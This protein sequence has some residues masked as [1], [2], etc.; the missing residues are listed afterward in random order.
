MKTARLVVAL[1]LFVAVAAGT[2]VLPGHR[3]DVAVTMWLQRAAPAP[4]L[5]SAILVFCGD[6]EVSIPAVALVGLLLWRGA[7]PRA[8]T[9]LWLAAGMIVTSFIALALKFV[10]PHPGPPPEFQRVIQRVGL[11]LQQPY[12][13]PSGHTMRATF[14]TIAALGRAPLAGAALVVAMMAALVYLGDHWTSDVLGGL[15]L[16]WACAEAARPFRPGA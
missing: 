4:D 11:G 15:C 7:L 13:F 8:R 10:V 14:F 5:P 3:W 1:I 12:S 6:A 9:A 16:G 2:F